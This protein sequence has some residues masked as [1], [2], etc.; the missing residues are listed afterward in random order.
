VFQIGRH[1]AARIARLPVE[2]AIGGNVANLNPNIPPGRTIALEPGWNGFLYT[3][4]SREVSDALSEIAGKYSA[5]LQYN[6]QAH[7]WQS[8][9]PGQPRYLNDF[10]GLLKLRIYWVEMTEAATI[11]LD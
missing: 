11:V 8:W 10:G 1:H 2:R 7:S 5:V 6:N 9:M 4:E 3:G